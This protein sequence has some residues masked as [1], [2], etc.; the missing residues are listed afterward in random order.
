[1]RS[2]RSRWSGVRPGELPVDVGHDR[3]S[4]RG[5]APDAAKGF[6]GLAVGQPGVLDAV[7]A[8]PGRRDDR[9]RTL[10][11]AH[12]PQVLP[13]RLGHDRADLGLGQLGIAVD[14]TA[15]REAGRREHRRLRGD[16]LDDTGPVADLPSNGT[17]QLAFPIGLDAELMAVAAGDPD[18]GAGGDQARSG[19][20]PRS[21]RVA[22][23]Q[24]EVPDGSRAAGGRDPGPQRPGRMARR[25][26]DDLGIGPAGD[27]RD[28]ALGRVEGVVGVRVDQPGEQR[29]A[30]AGDD[31]R[32]VLVGQ[33][34][35]CDPVPGDRGDPLAVHDY[36]HPVARLVRHAV[37]EPD[38]LED[39]AHPGILDAIP[40]PERSP[41]THRTAVALDS[42]RD[43]T[44]PPAPVQP[45]VAL[46][47][48]RPGQRAGPAD[49][50]PRGRRA[51]AA[52]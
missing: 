27:R 9:F 36:V 6:D 34:R 35:R 28:R 51:P 52:S 31:R 33:W 30:S 49:R 42:A 22:Q 2:W 16:D 17:D 40:R 24:L 41:G 47:R 39:R 38:V 14:E 37:D 15:G 18:R 3:G 32:R 44:Q 5:Q 23:D 50:E 45:G 29:P 13:V 43:R 20:V 12:D 19:H 1:M 21:D 7:D 48:L 25:G 8:R 10:G 46:L 26:Q 11:V 4:G